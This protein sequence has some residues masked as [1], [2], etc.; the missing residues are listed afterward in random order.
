M[1][2]G[3]KVAPIVRATNAIATEAVHE[4]GLGRRAVPAPTR[5]YPRATALA[6]RLWPISSRQ[7]ASRS[8][9]TWATRV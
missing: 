6:W 8:T 1:A 5:R 4:L 9:T 3:R 7:V 2:I